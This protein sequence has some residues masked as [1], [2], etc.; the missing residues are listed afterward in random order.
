MLEIVIDLLLSFRINDFNAS[1]FGLFTYLRM[2]E[3]VSE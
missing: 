3:R 2:R 1:F